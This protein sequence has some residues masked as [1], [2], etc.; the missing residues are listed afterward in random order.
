MCHI[1]FENSE[2]YIMH[3]YTP[4]RHVIECFLWQAFTPE[5][6]LKWRRLNFHKSEWAYEVFCIITLMPLVFRLFAVKTFNAE[7]RNHATHFD[8][9]TLCILP[10]NV[11]VLEFLVYRLQTLCIAS[12]EPEFHA[13]NAVDLMFKGSIL[14]CIWVVVD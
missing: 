5:N 3:S 8:L 10:K 14:R 1:V 13:K 2:F 9:L 11:A 12:F 6:I 4:V 7:S